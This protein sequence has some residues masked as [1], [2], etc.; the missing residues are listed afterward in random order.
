[1]LDL[2]QVIY[3]IFGNSEGGVVFCIFL[4]FLLD[5]LLFPTLPELFFALGCMYRSTLSFSIELLLAAALAEQI[6]IFSLYFVVKKVRIPSKVQRVADRYTRFLVVSDEKLLLLNRV[7]PMLP[8]AGAFISILKWNP[9]KCSAYIFLG[10]MLK[11]GLIAAL[12]SVFY[13]YFSSD[14]ASMVTLALIIIIIAVSMAM[15]TIMKKKKGLAQ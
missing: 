2:G 8:F 12:A 4:I 9:V 10:C 6:G 7:A 14:V 11:F 15:S 13:G 5:A 3:G 1:M